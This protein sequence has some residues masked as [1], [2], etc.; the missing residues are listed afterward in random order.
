MYFKNLVF[1]VKIVIL[2]KRNIRNVKDLIVILKLI[3]R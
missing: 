3:Y 1:F 2:N